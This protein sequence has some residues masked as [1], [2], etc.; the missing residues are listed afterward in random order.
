MNYKDLSLSDCG[1]YF[2]KNEKLLLKKTFI[3]AL[4]F[5]EPGLA[6]VKD[7]TGWYH[8]NTKGEAVYKQRYSRAFGF[9]Y[10]RAAVIE[11]KLWFHID[12]K[13]KRVYSENYVWCGNYQ[14]KLCTVRD[15][16]GNYFH[17][18]IE[19][20]RAYPEN[21]TYAGDFKD[22]YA[23]VRLKSGLYKHI[24][25]QGK[26]LNGKLFK[27]LGVFHKNY[28]TAKD[29]KGW[30]H[31]DKPGNELYSQRYVMIEPFYNGFALVDDFYSTKLII[32]ENGRQM[33]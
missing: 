14:E 11:I 23:A 16:E 24:D 30:F 17:I 12:I 32:D 31:I 13:G 33:I 3:E 10:N 5:H 20:K 8:I 6:P 22:G 28:A 2:L 18:D 19:G 27:D 15:F 29:E 9:Y 21:Y 4:K 7:E 25:Y 1:T 26:D